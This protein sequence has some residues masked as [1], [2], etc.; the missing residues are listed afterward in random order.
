MATDLV[1]PDVDVRMH[2]VAAAMRAATFYPG[3]TQPVECH[4]THIS[5]VFLTDRFAYKLKKPVRFEFVDFATPQARRR[6]CEAEVRLNRRLAPD[7]YL[8]VVPITAGAAGRPRLGGEGP[9]IDWVVKMRRLPAQCALDVLLRSGELMAADLDA[10]ARLLVR[11]YTQAAPLV[12]PTG[13]YRRKIEAHVR[14]NRDELLRSVHGL[15]S[16]VVRRVHAAQLR[17]VMLAPNVLDDRVRDGRIVDGHGDLRPEHIY[18]VPQPIAID[19]IEFSD[20]LRTI[21]V[22]DELA[23]FDMECQ[24]LGADSVGRR[25]REAYE[26]ESGDRPPDVLWDF[27]VTYRACVR[28]KVAALRAVQLLAERR[29]PALDEARQYLA[30]ADRHAALLGP[31]VVVVVRGT[32]GS[33]KSTLATAVADALGIELLQTDQVRRD[34]FPPSAGAPS[35]GALSAGTPP[36]G[37]PAAY[38]EGVYRPQSRQ[39][40]YHEMHRRAAVLVGQ[41]LSVVLDGTY[42]SA[43]LR[44]EA[45]Q[46]ARQHG[47]VPL[48]V[49][50][51][52]PAD[53]A[54][55]RIGERAAAGRTLSNA[56]P[57]TLAG[58]QE[59]DEPDP[60]GLPTLRV[61]TTQCLP[62]LIAA[63]FG[64]LGGMLRQAM[65][66]PDGG[67]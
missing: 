11:F 27:Y 23:F 57:A 2:D 47:A 13:E 61:D 60:P 49:Q 59:E 22:A 40:V 21:D 32:S 10:V 5:H 17:L 67:R 63:V 64:R 16:A 19:C 37:P 28:A 26:R 7:V 54:R 12:L 39:Q 66:R 50:C 29:G 45:V 14:A 20:E 62:A 58:Q 31:S 44:T 36:A 1:S 25:V 52:C 24:R 3:N 65:L 33:G 9:A 42:L 34:L 48:L 46:I 15:P 30:L 6:A 18:L 41:G 38:G 56:V 8:G 43:R 55:E 53:T 51:H 35:V 4:E